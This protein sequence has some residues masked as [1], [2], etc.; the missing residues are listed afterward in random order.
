MMAGTV[1]V[2]GVVATLAAVTLSLGVVGGAAIEAQRVA[3]I[4]DAAALAAADAASG[5][6]PGEPCRQAGRVAAAG[7]VHLNT[8]DLAGLVATIAVG[9][10]YG[11]VPFDAR[12]RA[13]PPD[14]F[15]P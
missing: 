15:A 13:G 1:S 6:V 7:E 11:G 4:A 9:G 12:S 14:A 10:A 8:C 3:G 2:V 5:A